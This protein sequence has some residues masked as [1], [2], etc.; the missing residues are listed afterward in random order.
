MLIQSSVKFGPTTSSAT[1][2]RP[3]C[4]PKLRTPSMA[5]SSLLAR[6]VMR[7]ISSTD[8]PGFSM[9]CIKKSVSWNSGRNSWPKCVAPAA[10][11]AN[12]PAITPSAV[13]GR[14]SSPGKTPR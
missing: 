12:V 7:S 14:A 9:K 1:S 13:Y 4:E 10:L 6:I 5:R 11:S 8:V 2:A 3:M